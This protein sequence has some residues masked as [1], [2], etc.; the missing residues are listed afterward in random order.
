MRRPTDVERGARCASPGPGTGQR[1]TVVPADASVNYR[2]VNLS[3][4]RPRKRAE[5]V[6]AGARL[7]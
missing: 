5:R 6:I 1:Y 7:V 2:R 3:R 4:P